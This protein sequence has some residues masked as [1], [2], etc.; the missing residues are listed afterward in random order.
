MHE[1]TADLPGILSYLRCIYV[2][3]EARGYRAFVSRMTNWHG[4]LGVLDVDGWKKLFQ[5]HT[6][7]SGM[8]HVEEV[9]AKTW[10]FHVSHT[11]IQDKKT[12]S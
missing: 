8:E 2:C 5:T 3:L 12:K 10:L 11:T 9:T 1:Y 7:S 6:A 4:T